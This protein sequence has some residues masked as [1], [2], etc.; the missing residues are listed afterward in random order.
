MG[1]FVTLTL[2]LHHGCYNINKGEKGEV[3][4]QSFVFLVSS[5]VLLAQI[6]QLNRDFKE[7]TTGTYAPGNSVFDDSI[8]GRLDRTSLQLLCCFP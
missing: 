1:V 7:C 3:F 8:F 6:L 4:K 5:S 2:G